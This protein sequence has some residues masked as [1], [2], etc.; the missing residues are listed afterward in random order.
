MEKK[1]NVKNTNEIQNKNNV[2][3][4]GNRPSYNKD[5]NKR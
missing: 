4:D 3:C 5:E 2:E 1:I